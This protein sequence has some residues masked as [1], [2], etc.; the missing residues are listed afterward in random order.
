[1]RPIA[2]RAG[3]T[4]I[5]LACQWN[6][7]H[8]PVQ[9]VAPTL[10]QEVGP[11]AKSI[12][13][14]RAELAALPAE[15]RLTHGD[16]D[17]IRTSG[18]QHRL[19]GAEGR[20]PA[21]HR[22]GATGSLDARRSPDHRRGAL[23]DRP[24]ARPRDGR[25]A[26]SAGEVSLPITGGCNCGAVRFEVTEPFE[27]LDATATARAASAAPARP[28]RPTG[29]RRP[30]RSGSSRGRTGSASWEPP[31]AGAD[32]YFCGDCGSALFSRSEASIG[33]RLGA[34]TAIPAS[35]PPT[36]S[37]SPTPP[38]GS[39]SPTT[40]CRAILR[41]DPRPEA[42]RRLV[43]LRPAR[44]ASTHSRPRGPRRPWPRPR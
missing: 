42:L 20:L 39:R 37:T 8:R 30:A 4:M 43:R 7:A 40:A 15:Q 23:A 24:R 35:G 11:E 1:M 25:G 5:Q 29:A 26:M 28:R 16:V 14:K 10:I 44:R 31:D 33:V 34:S 3:L 2:E 13:D 21:A 6:L 22:R 27:R 9:T 17:T 32:K 12:E 19:H 36:A 41:R 38:P 18:R